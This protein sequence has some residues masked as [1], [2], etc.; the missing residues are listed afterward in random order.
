MIGCGSKST[1]VQYCTAGDSG[2]V[3][4]QVAKIV[5]APNFATVGESVNFGQIGAS[6]SATSY[7]CKGNAVSST[8]YTY[9]TT[10]SYNVNLTGGPVFADINPRTGQV[11][12]G[13]WNRNVG[14]GIPDYTTCTPPSGQT[15]SSSIAANF[16]NPTTATASAG[17]TTTLTLTNGFVSG[18]LTV[19]LG[20]GSPYT[21]TISPAIPLFQLAG[22]INSDSGFKA[23]GITAVFDPTTLMLTLTGP[24][25]T[26]DTLVVAGSV[27]RDD[28]IA[29]LAYATATSNG[30]VSNPIAIYVHPVVTG[31]VL[32]TATPAANCPTATSPGIDPG[33]DC[34]LCSP[35]TTGTALS[36]PVYDGMSCLSQSSLKN[37]NLGQLVAACIP[38]AIRFQS[39]TSPAASATSP[40]PRRRRTSPPSI[41]TA[42]PRRTSQA[43]P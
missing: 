4:G 16:T 25:G 34:G 8:G 24:A 13:T 32:G 43:R 35:P 36:A 38:T 12:G 18:T 40:S 41:K 9:A 3:V 30:A 33:T 7:D 27:L 23:L 6:L 1:P 37:T 22:E 39:T 5:L 10:S 14:G 15:I 29:Y 19:A 11:C 28:A 31:I 2:P 26:A 21:F 20:N 17:S 42:S